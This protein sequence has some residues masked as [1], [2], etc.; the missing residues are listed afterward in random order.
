MAVREGLFPVV[1]QMLVELRVLFVGDL[2]GVAL[3]QS[4]GCIDALELRLFD[5][6]VFGFVFGFGFRGG[7]TVR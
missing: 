2:F 7:V 3:P 5:G 4:I 6:S 1:G